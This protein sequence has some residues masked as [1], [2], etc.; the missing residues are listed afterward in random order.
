MHWPQLLVLV[1]MVFRVIVEAELASLGVPDTKQRSPL[2]VGIWL[3]LVAAF[4]G[5][6][7]FWQ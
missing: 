6:G 1:W 4:L 7:G 2:R 3:G 5:F